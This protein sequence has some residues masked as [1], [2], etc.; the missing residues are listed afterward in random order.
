MVCYVGKEVAE[1]PTWVLREGQGC[2]IVDTSK[3]MP[4][5]SNRYFLQV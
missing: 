5:S 3:N 4:S 2:I 1:G